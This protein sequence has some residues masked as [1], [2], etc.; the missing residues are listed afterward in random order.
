MRANQAKSPFL[1]LSVLSVLVFV[2]LRLVGPG[3]SAGKTRSAPALLA[4]CRALDQ[5][6]ASR[7]ALDAELDAQLTAQLKAL[8]YLSDDDGSSPEEPPDAP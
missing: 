1:V 7:P 4:H 5:A 3:P 8:G 6:Y 2:A